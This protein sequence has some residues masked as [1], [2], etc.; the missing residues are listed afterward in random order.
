MV[1]AL[2]LIHGRFSRFEVHSMTTI[3]PL[4]FHHHPL[5]GTLSE[6][7]G[8]ELGLV[9]DHFGPVEQVPLYPGNLHASLRFRDILGHDLDDR[10]TPSAITLGCRLR[11]AAACRPN[12]H[13]KKR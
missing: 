5:S 9:V 12:R 8:T 3:P 13:V 11:R 2:V 1:V 4:E 7:F 10:N 6:H